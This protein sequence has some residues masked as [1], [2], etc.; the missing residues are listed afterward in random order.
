MSAPVDDMRP[1]GIRRVWDLTALGYR[2]HDIDSDAH[3][4]GVRLVRGEH[5]INVLLTR[6]DFAKQF[7]RAMQVMQSD[8]PAALE[9][10][11]RAKDE[12]SHTLAEVPDA[13]AQAAKVRHPNDPTDV[14]A[15]R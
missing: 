4:V 7:P 12:T 13:E 9:D 8:P 1:R 5:T 6:M 2:V 15:D 3:F 10:P 11:A 14:L